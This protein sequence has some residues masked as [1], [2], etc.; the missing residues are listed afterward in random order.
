MSHTEMIAELDQRLDA[1]TRGTSP[2]GSADGSA[3][4]PYT[5]ELDELIATA[6][7]AIR[8]LDV[9]L[10]PATQAR[11]LRMLKAAAARWGPKPPP[12]R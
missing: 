7:L 6:K 9:P 4:V 1:L 11:H 2:A 5:L 12:S 8:A 3:G 10:S